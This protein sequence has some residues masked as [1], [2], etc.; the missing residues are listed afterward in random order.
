[1]ASLYRGRKKPEMLDGILL[2]NQWNENEK[3]NFNKR[4]N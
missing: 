2:S 1:M 3:M 4:T